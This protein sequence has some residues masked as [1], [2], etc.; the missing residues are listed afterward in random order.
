[1]TTAGLT[2]VTICQAVL[3]QAGK[4]GKLLGKLGKAKRAG[5]AWMLDEFSVRTNRHTGKHYHYYLYGLE[6]ACEIN[7]IA[8][9]GHRD[10]YFEGANMLIENQNKGSAERADVADGGAGGGAG[11]GGRGVRRGG[12]GGGGRAGP[13]SFRGAGLPQTCMAILFLKQSAPP[14]PVLTGR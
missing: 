11:G 14:L 10:W 6:R 9:L 12:F 4:G 3:G 1:M 8:L 7:Q 13:G 5:L 2:G